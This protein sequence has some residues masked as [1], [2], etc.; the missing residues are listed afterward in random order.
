MD[1]TATDMHIIIKPMET[2]AEIKGKA[3][4][5]WQA[6]HEAYPSLVSP[7]FLAKLT[8]T[9]CEE[10]AHHWT[11]GILVAKD[12]ERVVGFVGYGDRGD[13]AEGV[14]EIFALYVLSE[15]YGQGVGRALM[16]AALAHLRGYVYV[17][18]WVLKKNARAVRFYEKCGFRPSGEEMYS[19][20]V[21]AYEIRMIRQGD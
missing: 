17:C 6:W 2:E 4:V 12:G 20:R 18:L 19:E 1:A 13:D 5:H 14:G 7:D 21:E 3:Y 10:M 16:E 11:D 9:R 8:L 15:Y